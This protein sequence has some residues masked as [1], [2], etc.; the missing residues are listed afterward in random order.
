MKKMV[1]LLCSFFMTGLVHAD[2]I[3]P[4]DDADN[5]FNSFGGTIATNLIAG[6]ITLI[7]TTP[8][9]DA[10]IDW[11]NGVSNISMATEYQLT[12]TPVADYNGGYWSANILFFDNGDYLAE[13]TWL[14]DNNSTA[15]RSTNI[16][17][18]AESVGGSATNAN[19]YFVRFR[20][21]PF[22]QSDVGFSFT[23]ITAVPEPSVVLLLLLSAT[24]LGLSGRLR[25][26]RR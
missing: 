23:Q 7:R 15:I 2:V 12:I 24:V 21:Q 26:V 19:N 13:H 11:R 1:W 6:E 20:A 22:N 5:F 18:F 9:V 17:V 25:S 4:L 3:D 14:S 16:T 8:N 10:G